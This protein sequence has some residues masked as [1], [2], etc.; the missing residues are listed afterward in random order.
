VPPSVGTTE[1]AFGQCVAYA[2][3]S[4]ADSCSASTCSDCLQHSRCGWCG[5]EDGSGTCEAGTI[6]HSGLRSLNRDSLCNGGSGTTSTTTVTVGPGVNAST[7]TSSTSI[8]SASTSTSTPWT[9]TTMLTN[10]WTW[11][12]FECPDVNECEVNPNACDAIGTCINVD[13]RVNPERGYICTCPS[14]YTLNVTDQRTCVPTCTTY[15]CIS[16]KCVAPDVCE[17][18]LGYRGV[19]CA[20]D[21]GCNGHSACRDP[22]DN[23]T[24]SK[25]AT[26]SGNTTG[27]KCEQ[28]APG[29]TGNATNGGK[30][31]SCVVAC[32]NHSSDCLTTPLTIGGVVCRNCSDHTTGPYC[33]YCMPGYFLHPEIWAASRRLRYAS[34]RAYIDAEVF[35]LC[36]LKCWNASLLIKFLECTCALLSVSMQQTRDNV[37]H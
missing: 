22:S 36:F 33:Q 18:A 11:A 31:T 15:G 28:C 13:N 29:F 34:A 19:D 17:C 37:R 14:N 24:S 20:E 9:T 1:L 4:C 21:C 32:N 5:A 25:C 26:C 10:N 2:G 16:G 7:S 6:A 12:F 23:T 35:C 8:S 3:D 27:L 30:C